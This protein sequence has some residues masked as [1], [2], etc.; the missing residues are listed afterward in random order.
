MA[1]KAISQLNAATAVT[2]TDLFVL[3]QAGE[4]KKLTGQILENWLVSYADGHGGIQS[5]TKTGSA[6]T[7]PVIDTYPIVFADETTA[8]FTVTNGTKGGIGLSVK[9][10]KSITAKTGVTIDKTLTAD[11]LAEILVESRDVKLAKEITKENSLLREKVEELT[12][13]R[14]LLQ[15][16]VYTLEAELRDVEVSHNMINEDPGWGVDKDWGDT[17]GWGKNKGWGEAKSWDVEQEKR[18]T[19]VSWDVR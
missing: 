13:S 7:D 15:E 5:I 16:R 1:D 8:S 11:R 19:D 10:L 4:A 12:R 18:G 17:T 6:G 2:S 14:D 3:E 9:Q